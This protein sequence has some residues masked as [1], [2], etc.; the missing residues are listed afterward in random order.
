MN[1]NIHM[2][3]FFVVAVVIFI[4]IQF[5]YSII[6]NLLHLFCLFVFSS[7]FFLIFCLKALN[8]HEKISTYSKIIT[9]LHNL[10]LYFLARKCIYITNL[11]SILLTEV[12]I[13]CYYFLMGGQNVLETSNL[14]QIK[15]NH[16]IIEKIN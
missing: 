13:F 9:C 16:N 5:E 1:T 8:N 7:I 4:F 2:F 15:F 10:L 3:C 11:Q 6:T 14:K 12:H